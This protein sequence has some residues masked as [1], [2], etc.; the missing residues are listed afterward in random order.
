MAD[1]G[2]MKI[3]V[4]F[5]GMVAGV[6]QADAPNPFLSGTLGAVL[7]GAGY[8]YNDDAKSAAVAL[9][10]SIPVMARHFITTPTHQ[11]KTLKQNLGLLSRN[12]YA[13][14]V[15]DSYQ[16]ALDLNGRPETLVKVPRYPLKDLVIAPLKLKHYSNDNVIIPVGIAAAMATLKVAVDGVKPGLDPKRA[17]LAIPLLIAQSLFIGAG[18]E[19]EF[20]GFYYPAFSELTGSRFIGNVMQG[21]LF[22]ACHTPW[23][24]CANPQLIGL[25]LE[26][27]RSV[28]PTREY[29]SRRDPSS[30]TVYRTSPLQ[31]FINASLMGMYLGYVSQST[32]DGLLR[33]IALHSTWDAVLLV[34]DFLAEGDSPFF[35]S[36]ELPL[37]L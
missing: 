1:I 2:S 34:A 6:A 35:F 27:L 8:F 37:T 31:Y 14:T 23:P 16:Q 36:V 28:D 7:P 10:V 32:D 15:Y 20:R 17:V 30:P 12:L 26:E 11:S 18:E 13:F 3:L 22:G 25:G 9:G 4:V 33:A 19:S 24:V 21:A 29:G 5:L